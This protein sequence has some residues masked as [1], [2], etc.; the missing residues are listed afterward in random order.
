MTGKTSLSDLVYIYKNVDLLITPDSGSAH[1]A[2]ASNCNSI[3]TLFFAT[4][5]NRTAPFGENYYSIRSDIACSPCMKKK[6]RLKHNK[7]ACIEALDS[8][9]VINIVN[10]VLQ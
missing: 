4:S 10:N 7:N 5:K 9:K 3:I 2:W 6:C 8:E 1:I